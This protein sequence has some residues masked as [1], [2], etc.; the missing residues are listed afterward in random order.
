MTILQKY[1][2]RAFAGVLLLPLCLTACGGGAESG[3]SSRVEISIAESASEPVQQ[4]TWP[5]Y[6]SNANGISFSHPENWTVKESGNTITVVSPAELDSAIM[7]ADITY[8]TTLFLAG[9]GDLET[10]IDSLMGKYAD[11][12]VEG[13][14]MENYTYNWD[15]DDNGEMVST[16]SFTYQDGGSYK[17]NVVVDQVGGRVFLIAYLCPDTRKAE[18][19]PIYNQIHQSV[20]LDNTDVPLEAANLT[21]LGF[22]E[23]PAGFYRFYN[24][25]TGQFFM[26]PD[27]WDLVTSPH[28]SYVMLYNDRGAVMITENW[29]DRFYEIYNSNGKD[30]KE[31]FDYFLDECDSVLQEFWEEQPRYSGFQYLTT[32]NQELI[33]GAFDYTVGEGT[34]RCF[35]E[36]GVRPFNGDDKIQGTMCMYRGGDQYSIDLFSVIMDSTVIYYP[37]L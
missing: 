20:L 18:T 36:L 5:G 9:H 10:S 12:L 28:D 35:A 3:G 11:M 8:E 29:T 6:E 16:C 32:K 25:V 7:L 19:D 37:V 17:G 23:A 22:P 33:K 30:E 4:N 26:Y 24:P 27:D 31:C 34:G 13:A 15:I 21:D 14:T 1:L 2:I